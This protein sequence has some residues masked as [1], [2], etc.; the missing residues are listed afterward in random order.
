MKSV[1]LSYRIFA[2]SM[3]VIMFAAS[4]NLAVDMH[5]CQG[6]LKSVNFFG[7]A[8]TCHDMVAAQMPSCPHHQKML[9][10]SADCSE[11]KKGCCNNR[12][13]HIQSDTDQQLQTNADFVVSQEL[14]HFV[15]AFVTTFFLNNSVEESSSNSFAYQPPTIVR[16]TYVLYETF[17][18]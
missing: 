16:D 1:N 8:K 13:V 12:S 2:L 9:E 4:V 6:K 7:K 14:E 3:A 17:L 18:L 10:K 15:T 5:F 11:E